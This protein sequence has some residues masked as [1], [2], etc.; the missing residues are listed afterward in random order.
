MT[1]MSGCG[2]AAGYFTQQQQTYTVTVTGTEGAL[3]HSATVS[4]TVQ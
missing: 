4:L 1:W 2:G 3:S